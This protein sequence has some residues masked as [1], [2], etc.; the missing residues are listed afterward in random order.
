MNIAFYPMGDEKWY[1]GLVHL[2]SLFYALQYTYGDKVKRYLISRLFDTDNQDAFK[3]VTDSAIAI[4]CLKS[5]TPFWLL[6][7]IARRLFNHYLKDEIFLRK[8]KIDAIFGFCIQY[9]YGSIPTLSYIWDFQHKHL[10]KMFSEEER[11][12]RDRIFSQSAKVS[13]RLI[14]AS[15][16]IKDDVRTFLPNYVHKV[17][18]IR[19]VI[20]I[21]E[22]IY[23]TEP[24]SITK[25]Y[26][27]PEK[28]IYLPSQFWKHKNHKIVF[29]AVKI[30]KKRGMQIDIVCT[31]CSEDYRNPTYFADLLKDLSN[32]DHK[33]QIRYLGM[34]SYEHV[35]LLM[36]QSI[37]VLNP[38]LFE[39]FG[40]T[41]SEA[42]SLGK[43]VLLS[44]ISPHHEHNHP[45]AT[46]FNPYDV[47]DVAEKLTT[48]WHHATPGPDPESEEKARKELP[49]RIRESAHSLMSVANE[50]V[51]G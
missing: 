41:S 22:S 29:D 9:Y 44:D 33:G 12:N 4:P 35:L 3:A 16:T 15:K 7:G 32:W 51:N 1:G 18:V 40:I 13:F 37:C 27:L 6:D 34:I 48:I 17:R 49:G 5:G 10:P 20:N 39:G 2:R 14:V 23:K 11:F 8:R 30:L 25:L 19:P 50:A 43:Q 36:R 26:N 31:G 47:G 28:F 46:F 24:K 45:N 42:K 21:P 38:S